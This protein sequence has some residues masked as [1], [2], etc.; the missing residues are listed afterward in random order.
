MP[1]HN[2]TKRRAADTQI[3]ARIPPDLLKQIDDLTG[4]NSP[5]LLTRNGKPTTDRLT[6]STVVR[7]AIQAG[8]DV[9]T[10]QEP[11]EL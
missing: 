4:C 2:A 11:L 9:L 1:R 5:L 6:R 10:T 8:L 7:L 3:S